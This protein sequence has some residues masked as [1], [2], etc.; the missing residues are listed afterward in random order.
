MA[1][2]ITSRGAEALK[3]E[4]KHLKTVARPE[5][6]AAI[7][8]ARA[9]GDLKE[10]AEY[11]AAKEQQSF[12]EGRIQELESVLS[13]AQII[14]PATLPQE[15]RVVFGVT[16]TLLNIDTDQEVK[17]QIVGDY[18]SDI[19]LNRISVSS[20]IARALIGKEIDDVAT[21]QAPGGNIEYEIVEIGYEA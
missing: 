9:H 10:N 8:E 14:D 5:V 12:I 15:G 20:P 3:E 7:S 4:L 16:V 19:K 11:H 18:E 1:V 13:N 21:V 2:P 17:Y 6:V